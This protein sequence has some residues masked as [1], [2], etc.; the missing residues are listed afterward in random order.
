VL[1]LPLGSL[2]QSFFNAISTASVHEDL[3]SQHFHHLHKCDYTFCEANTF[4]TK[5]P[6]Y[7]MFQPIEAFLLAVVL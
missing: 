7:K 2:K 6:N 5:N 3:K 4:G 1:A